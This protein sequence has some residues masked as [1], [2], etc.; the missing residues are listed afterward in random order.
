[1]AE[2]KKKGGNGDVV[3]ENGIA[4]KILRNTSQK[5]KRPRFVRE[6][7]VLR[8]LNSEGINSIVQVISY[9]IEATNPW[10]TMPAYSGDGNDIV[11]SSRGDVKKSAKLLLPIADALMRLSQLEIPIFHR[12]LKPENL[13]VDDSNGEARLL[14]A[15]F[16]C[17]YFPSDLNRLTPDFWAI[18]AANYRAPEYH[19]GRV[20]EVTEKGDIFSLGKIFWFFINGVEF[21]IF[22]YTLWFP[23]IYNLTKRFPDAPGISKANLLIAAATHHDPA[24]RLT[25]AQFIEHLREMTEDNSVTD[26]EEELRLNGLLHDQE[27][28][29][30]CERQKSIAT[31][32]IKQFHADMKEALERLPQ[33]Q[34]VNRMRA[35]SPFII[36]DIVEGVV[37]KS[38]NWPVWNYEGQ[39][40]HIE[41]R[42][43]PI[44]DWLVSIK[45]QPRNKSPFLVC[46]IK[47]HARNQTEKSFKIIYFFDKEA[48]LS[49]CVDDEISTHDSGCLHR[50]MKAMIQ[51][52]L[53]R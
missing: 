28:L 37:D 21:D 40:V 20:E 24:M 16:G 17:A 3:I 46:Y 22:P 10:Y 51:H 39:Q 35:V 52:F 47:A 25:Y 32:I 11:A 34:E 53:Q 18:G 31:N 27:M 23:E 6:I 41:T 48:G 14:L 7:D 19:R 36:N 9:D 1:M 45:I 29:L 43:Y 38:S 15:D 44:S 26:D 12:D 33:I 30:E 50:T 49:I 2:R 5:D 8:K 42:M 13:L 4:K